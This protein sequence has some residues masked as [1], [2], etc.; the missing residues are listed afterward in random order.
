MKVL[1]A[2]EESQRVCIAF[3]KRGH[4]AFSCDILECSGGH[5]EWHLKG[6]ALY[7]LSATKWD[8]VIAHPP[9]TYLTNTGNRWYNVDKYGEKA[10]QRYR[11]RNG[12]IDFF[13]DFV[14]SPYCERLAIE[15][16]IGC[17]STY[18]RK[19]DQIIHPYMFGDPER[20]ATCLWLKNL[21]LLK[22]TNIVQPNIIKYKNGKG[23]DSPWH[24]ETMKLPKEE[25]ARM[26]SKTFPGIAEAMAIQWGG[27][28]NE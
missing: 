28:I 16:P 27:V 1:I 23:T 7:Y 5:P 17:M 21:P 19:P 11:L 26:R 25:R 14:Y 2:C 15:N 12:A 22:A 4:E 8:L 9:C 24:M 6:D 20:K 3:R 10:E 18:Y 13:M